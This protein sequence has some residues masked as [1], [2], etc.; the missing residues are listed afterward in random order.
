MADLAP[1]ERDFIAPIGVLGGPVQPWTMTGSVAETFFRGHT[2]KDTLLVVEPKSATQGLS[3]GPYGPLGEMEWPE[4][5]GEWQWT[6]IGITLYVAA[7]TGRSSANDDTPPK[8]Y[9]PGKLKPFNFGVSLFQGAKPWA[10]SR[11]GAGAITLIDPDQ[12]LDYLLPYIWDNAPITLKRGRRGTYFNTWETVGNYRSSALVYDINEKILQLRDLGWQLSGPI[13]NEVYAGTGGIEGDPERKGQFKPWALGYCFNIP[14]VLISASSQIFQFSLSSSQAVLEVRHGG[15]VLAFHQDYADFATLAAA[16][17][18]SGKYGTC[19]AQSLVR[20]VL[21]MDKSIR[22]DVIGDADVVLGYPGPTTR[23]NIVRRLACSRGSNVLDM[24]SEIDDASFNQMEAMHNAPVGWFFGSAVSKADAMDRVLGGILG[25]WSMRPNGRL[26]IGWVQD[27]ATVTPIASLK[28]KRESME[29][30][31]CT[32]VLMP[33]NGTFVGF[34]HN[35]GPEQRS[36]MSL[37]VSDANSAIY[38]QTARYA[39]STSTAVTNAYP[40]SEKVVVDETGFW[41]EADAL[42]EAQRQQSIFAVERRAWEFRMECDP[43]VDV[44]GRVLSLTDVNSLGLGASTPMLCSGLSTP[45]TGKTTFSF[46]V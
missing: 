43:H 12:R 32:E 37:G 11:P 3:L 16:S 8:Q 29:N 21:T 23:A 4:A 42:L 24:A 19:L 34:K 1:D 27:P 30:L 2:G 31:R 45:G 10:R 15:S 18:P 36:A 5:S 7:T 46:F 6:G 28:Y 40:T 20:P 35:Y 17:I 38:S 44:I 14:P 33:R 41:L 39:S 25:W 13:H 22:L 9:V 26:I